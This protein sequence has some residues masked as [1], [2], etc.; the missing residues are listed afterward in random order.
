MAEAK[1]HFLGVDGKPMRARDLQEEKA[2]PTLTGVRQNTSAHPA[3]GLTP[4]RLARLL[5]EA[6]DG[7]PTRYLELA[8]DME[9]RDLHYL[10]VIGTRKRSIAQ[11]DLTVEAA[12]EDKASQEQ[13]EAV[14]ELLARDTIE[15]ELF[16]VLDAVGKGFSVCEVLWDTGGGRWWPREIKH[17]DPRWFDFDPADGATPRLRVDGGWEPIPIG[18][19]KYVYHVHKAKSGLAIRGGL[20]RLA[21]WSF[22]FKSF[23]LKDW[24][25]FCEVFGQPLRLGKYGPE[26][27]EDDKAKLLHAVANIGSDVAAIVPQSMII[28]FVEAKITG[29]VELYEKRCDWLDRQVSK[30]VLGQTTTTDAISG[31]HAVSQEHRQV[32]K[33]IERADAKQVSAT[34]NRDIIRPF[35]AFNFGPQEVYPRAV[36]GR[37]EAV[38]T[39]KLTKAVAAL[40]PLG[41]KVGQQW[42][43]ETLGIPDPQ[44]DEELLGAPKPAVPPAGEEQEEEEREAATQARRPAPARV[45]ARA[46]APTPADAIDGLLDGIEWEPLLEETLAPIRQAV[47]TAASLEE[48]QETLGTL[49]PKLGVESLAQH[50]AKSLFA[51]RLSGELNAPIAE[52]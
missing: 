14:R 41:L 2:G 45:P 47:A 26:A 22:M 42:A 31:G 43:R 27:T 4:Q 15:D 29:N 49:L 46:P 20:A 8:E 11:L 6:E 52:S 19:G 3:V 13:A 30:A 48:L 23:T 7:D 40:V 9:E 5:R 1:R 28:E 32:Q 24:A 16:D 34:I 51:A 25:V 10:G 17:R 18:N 39:E 21:A 36:L 37:A 35:I 38:D 12:D 44:D 33:D 50:L